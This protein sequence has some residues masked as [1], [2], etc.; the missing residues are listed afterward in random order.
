MTAEERAATKLRHERYR[1]ATQ[2]LYPA[3][4]IKHLVDVV[5]DADR[6]GAFVEIVVWVGREEIEHGD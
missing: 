5:E 1:A 3:A 2:R 6:A 4:K